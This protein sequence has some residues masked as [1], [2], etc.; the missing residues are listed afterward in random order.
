MPSDLRQEVFKTMKIYRDILL[1]DNKGWKCLE[2]GIDGDERPSGNYKSFGLGNKWA[3]MD[4]VAYLKPDI[5][6]DLCDTGLDPEQF[7]L[8]IVSQTLEH[9]YDFTKAIIECE[10]LLKKDGYLIIDCPFLY[11]FHGT[12]DYGDYWRISH[13]AMRKQLQSAGLQVVSCEIFSN[14]LTSALAKK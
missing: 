3:T 13:Q 1:P 12:Q 8:I 7:D 4:N 6:A 9:I 14:L 2:V 5:V 10:R 11:P